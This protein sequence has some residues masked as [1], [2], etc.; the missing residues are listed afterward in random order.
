MATFLSKLMPARTHVPTPATSSTQPP[1]MG[2]VLAAPRHRRVTF[3]H[4]ITRD[5]LGV[6]GGCRQDVRRMRLVVRPAPAALKRVV[7]PERTGPPFARR[8]P[9]VIACRS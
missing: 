6:G 3:L 5:A 2:L 4:A 8:S 1:C 9:T 7:A